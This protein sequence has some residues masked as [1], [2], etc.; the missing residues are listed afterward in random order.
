MKKKWPLISTLI[1]AVILL[2]ACAQKES[3]ASVEL[4]IDKVNEPIVIGQTNI[5]SSLHPTDSGIPWSLTSHGVSEKLFTLNEKGELVSRIIDSLEQMDENTWKATMKTDVLFSDGSSINADS[6]VESMSRILEENAFSNSTAGKMVLTKDSEYSFTMK[7]ERP[8]KLMK[9]VLAEWTYII[10]K[11]IA[12]SQFVFSGPYMVK[13][14][15]AGFE[16]HLTPNPYYPN[17]DKRS[18]VVLRVFKDTSTMKLA[19]EAGDIDMAF[20]VTP[21]VADMLEQQGALVKSIDA[22]YQYFSIVNLEHKPLDDLKVRK[23]LSQAL[24]RADMVK[25]LHGGRVATGAFAHYYSFAGHTSIESNQEVAKILLNEAGWSPNAD[26]M[27]EK[28]GKVL[29]LRLVTYASRPDLTLLMQIA[30]SQLKDLGID[31]TTEI[32]DNIDATAGKGDYDIIFYAQHTAPTGDP[33]FFLNQFF[34]P[35]GGKN[36]NHYH[37]SELVNLLDEMGELEQGPERD[38]VAVKAQSVIYE[39]LPILYLVDPQWHIAV[40]EKLKNYQPYGGDYYVVN[41]QL[42]L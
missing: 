10:F 4:P 13:S 29:K 5:A 37:S 39:D 16:L 19:Y 34:R 2:A 22:G 3:T 21:E 40:S 41:D 9:S 33:A 8:I 7:T 18:D 26:G 36:F 38:A 12:D 20:T 11:E 23:A 15:N 30:A 14:F 17:A 6:V 27:L 32:V 24:N 28:D 42:G 1:I 35:D 31:T 25:A